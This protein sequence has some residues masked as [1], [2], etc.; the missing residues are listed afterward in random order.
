M[1]SNSLR[2]SASVTGM[3][4]LKVSKFFTLEKLMDL[5]KLQDHKNTGTVN[6]TSDCD[7]GASKHDDAP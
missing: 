7:K 5:S 4:M 1:E 2:F 6:V 3:L